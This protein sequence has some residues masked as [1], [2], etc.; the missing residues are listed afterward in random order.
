MKVKGV[1]LSK[2]NG[3]IKIADVKK[4][5]FEFAILRGGYT[6]YGSKRPKVKDQKRL[7]FLEVVIIILAPLANKVEF[8][9]LNFCMKIVLKVSSLNTRFISTFKNPDGRPTIKK[10]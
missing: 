10:A 6:G 2:H 7:I 8:M 9:K 5:G 3:S 1:D 4:V